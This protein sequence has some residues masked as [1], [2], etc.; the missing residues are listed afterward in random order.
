MSSIYLFCCFAKL[1]FHE[2]FLC[3]RSLATTAAVDSGE[4]PLYGSNKYL[5]LGLK[6]WAFTWKI[7]FFFFL[8]VPCNTTLLAFSVNIYK[9]HKLCE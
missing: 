3:V 8:E 1:Q 9:N 6:N 7:V 2:F 4:R 5:P